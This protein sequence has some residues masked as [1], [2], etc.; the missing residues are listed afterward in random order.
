MKIA[1]IGESVRQLVLK[2][3]K[4]RFLYDLLLAYGQPKASITRLES[5]DK[6]SYNLS[7]LDGV[8]LWKKKVLYATTTMDDVEA[9][10][11]VLL[12]SQAMDKH[13]PRFVLVTNFERIYAIDTKTNDK[14]DILFVELQSR[15][16]F[17]L[18]WAGME[19]AVNAPDN[20][21]DVKAAEKMAK[22]FDL[23]KADNPSKDPKF[24]HSLNVFL[25]R[26]LFCLFAE[27]TGIFTDKLFTNSVESH[28]SKDGS[29]LQEYLDT[30]FDVLNME[31]RKNLPAYLQA[32][33]YVN[34]GLFAEKHPA[35]NFSAKS[36]SILIDCGADLNW[37]EINPDIFGSMIQAVVDVD[38]RGNMGMHY[39]SV[40]NIMKV[41][42][43]LFLDSLYAEFEKSK[44]SSK[45]LIELQE[46]ICRINIFDPACGSG[47]FLI[48]AYKELRKLEMEIFNQLAITNKKADFGF[49]GIQ[50]AQF[51]GIELDDFA[52]EVA[53]L[54]LW[55]A[56]HQ[57]NVAFMKRFNR[58]SPTLPLKP[59]GN[60]ICEN[61]ARIDWNIVCPKNDKSEIYIL[62]NPPYY[63]SKKQSKDQKIDIARVFHHSTTYKN[64]DYIS[65]WFLLAARYI[66]DS[67]TRAGFVTTNS[68]VQGDQVGLLWPSIFDLGIAINFAYQPF[69]W[70]NNAKNKAGVTCVIIGLANNSVK[71]RWIYSSTQRKQVK[72]ISPYLTDASNVIVYKRNDTL[73]QLP[74]MAVGNMSLDGGFLKLE[75]EEKNALIQKYPEAA[76]FIRPITGGNEF[77]YG[78][79]RW[80][81]W[82]ED[83]E[84]TRARRIPELSRR[85]DA[86]REFREGGGEVATTLL[87]RSHQFRYR[88]TA[89]QAM[90]LIP[91]TSSEKREFLQVG[92]LGAGS[93][94]LHSAQIVY[95][96]DPYVFGLVSSRMHMLWT[97][98]TCGTLD[99]RV[100]YSNKISYNNFPIPLITKEKK[101][102]ISKCSMAILGERERNSELT[103]ADMY[104]PELMP[105]SLLRAH[106]LLDDAIESCYQNEPFKSDDERLASLFKLFERLTGEQRA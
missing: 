62:G 106:K 91:C 87:E 85:I 25:S 74:E 30:L 93:I 7:K 101:Q 2:P 15:F 71:G 66:Q 103:I 52:H 64:L 82:I 42:E 34:G 86:V 90:L 31:K 79:E 59:S 37:S 13:A 36:R 92:Y 100:R 67:N 38:Q 78:E 22:L 33:P 94:S 73:S 105:E 88:R 6:G 16:D 80:C 77:L 98:A 3:D 11:E 24:N 48:I 41:I 55:L 8:V 65:C 75:K 51:Y 84:L 43:P 44:E 27:D 54:A 96:A 26:V 28:T 104:D 83:E 56:E 49:S 40:T 1:E 21:A 46:R 53:I 60:I 14:L 50:L 69:K 5:T 70:S 57:M 89:K 95:D 61:A 23:I 10:A 20:P 102:F 47:N 99:A 18:P 97:K 58:V 63:G 17:F 19:K 4:D 68:I 76:K 35:P 32:F 29:D 72:N 9:F 12:L 39:T 45:K 81:I